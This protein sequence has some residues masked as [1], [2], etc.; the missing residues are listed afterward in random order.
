MSYFS[1][2]EKRAIIAAPFIGAG[3]AIV[4]ELIKQWNNRSGF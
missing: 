2:N 1:K 4:E 3:L